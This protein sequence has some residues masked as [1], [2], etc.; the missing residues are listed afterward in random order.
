MNEPSPE[1]QRRVRLAEGAFLAIC[2]ALL[3]HNPELG[4][5]LWWALRTT[6]NTQF[7]GVAN[8]DELIHIAF[9]AP[10]SQAVHDL[11]ARLFNLEC[12]NTDQDLLNLACAAVSN[13][14]GPWL[15][16]FIGEGR[17]SEAAWRRMRAETL[18]GFTSGNE[19]PLAEAW[20]EGESKAQGEL[21]VRRTD[22]LKWREAW[23]R[24][25]WQRFIEAECPDEAYAYW[26]CFSKS[27]DLRALSWIESE[28]NPETINNRFHALKIAQ[29]RLNRSS[30]AETWGRRGE[31]FERTYLHRN[32]VSGIGP[33]A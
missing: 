21:L 5:K 2:E 17:R 25:W 16:K 18:D 15:S 22:Q 1:F 11:R 26:V 30:L 29:A 9:R 7:T 8:I 3:G 27:S 32:I 19:L 31:R 23:C 33:W 10:E 14:R 6:M 12:S 24:H 4:A 20:P 28:S 13:G